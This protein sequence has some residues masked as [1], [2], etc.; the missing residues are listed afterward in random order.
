[1]NSVQKEA[2]REIS[3]SNFRRVSAQRPVTTHTSTVTWAKPSATGADYTAR[4]SFVASANRRSAAPR[5]IRSFPRDEAWQ[6]A[7]SAQERRVDDSVRIGGNM[8]KKSGLWVNSDRLLR[9]AYRPLARGDEYP[10]MVQAQDEGIRVEDIVQAQDEEILKKEQEILGGEG[11]ATLTGGNMQW[12]T[13]AR[14]EFY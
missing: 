9:A 1:M 5:V 4:R 14:R 6:P 7:P 2:M 10:V 8:V 13:C 11:R 12:E 3:A